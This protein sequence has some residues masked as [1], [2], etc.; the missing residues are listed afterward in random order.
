MLFCHLKEELTMQVAIPKEITQ[1]EN[2]VALVPHLVPEL[3][4]LGCTVL[5]ENNAGLAA[6]YPDACYQGVTFC[7]NAQRLYSQADIILKI[8]PP[9]PEE[10]ALMKAN[11]IVI[12][13]LSPQRFPNSVKAMAKHSITSFALELIPRISRA[14]PMDALSSQATV[15]G[16]KAAL[17][18]A[19]WLNRFFPMLTT[20]AGTI[21]PANILVIGAGVAG[22]QAIATCRRLGA[23]VKAYDVRAAAREQV[24]SLGAKMIQIAVAGEAA[25]GYAREL[26]PQEREQ[27]Q[28]ALC[29]AITKADAVITTALI[30][31]KKAPLIITQSM[32]KAMSPGAVIVDMAAVAGGN[33]E[34][35]Q[36]GRMIDYEGIKIDGPLNLP[37][38]VARDASNMYAK[39]ILNFLSLMIKDKHLTIDWEDTILAQSILTFEG[40]IKHSATRTWIEE[41]SS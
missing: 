9:S 39:N 34:L 14:Q 6:D 20:A 23:V 11:A 10:I 2:R 12:G 16:Y 41:Q 19:N 24:E 31:G 32:I 33:C 37:S 29:E 36:P 15:A 3:T 5:M 8:D 38:M 35:T 30:P 25:G 4:R 17:I 18:A 26:T 7:E 1:A 28:A 21:R 13:L 27:Q 40:A 22:L